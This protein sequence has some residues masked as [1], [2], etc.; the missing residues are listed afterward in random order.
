LQSGSEYLGETVPFGVDLPGGRIIGY[1]EAPAAVEHTGKG[2]GTE[3][4]YGPRALDIGKHI[5][6]IVDDPCL[7]V[8]VA[9]MEAGTYLS[10]KGGEVLLG[11]AVEV[12][13]FA[14]GVVDDL[15]LGGA[16]GEKDGRTAYKWFAVK[17]VPRDERDDTGGE[18]LLAAVIADGGPE[19]DLGHV[20]YIKV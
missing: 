6:V 19:P 13:Q 1:V 16:L 9:A 12:D 2:L 20:Y 5:G 11:D 17:G 3:H 15:D 10:L 8:Q 7:A 18:L 14:V 4:P